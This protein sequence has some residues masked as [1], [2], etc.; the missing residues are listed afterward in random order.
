MPDW[1]DVGPADLMDGE[2]RGLEIGEDLMAISIG[3]SI[4][5]QRIH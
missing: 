3:D 2:L 4:A 5:I 1:I